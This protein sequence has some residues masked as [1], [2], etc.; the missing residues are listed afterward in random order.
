M[1]MKNHIKL[2]CLL[3]TLIGL[4]AMGV[5]L[6]YTSHV[7]ASSM[8]EDPLVQDAKVY[9]SDQGITLDEAVYRLEIQDTIGEFIAEITANEP[10]TFA[11]AWIQ[12]KPNYSIIVQFTH[13]GEKVIEPYFSNELYADLKD[14]VEV[15][16]AK[17]TLQELEAT[18]LSIVLAARDLGI[19]FEADIN[20]F[21]NQVK[22]YVT[23]PLGFQMALEAADMAIPDYVILIIVSGFSEPEVNIYAGLA[24]SE[25]TSGYSV[26]NPSGTKYISTAGHCGNTISYNGTN[27]PFVD[28]QYN[29]AGDFQYH[30]FSGF[31]IKNWA[32]DNLCCD[33]TPYYRVITATKS[34]ADQMLNE[35]VCKYG[36]TT[37]LTCGYIISKNVLPT[38]PP[39]ATATYIR[40]HRDGVNLSSGGDSGG[41]WYVGGTA[42]GVH[43]SAPGAP[44]DYDAI[45][46]AVNYFA[47]KNL[48]VM[49]AP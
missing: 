9:A 5:N 32:T 2:F 16:S 37:G 27:L 31:T 3:T 15:R 40:V 38:L 25:C 14:L 4:L 7:Q 8:D 35:F 33:S 10:D 48:S 11:G 18:Q 6:V 17:I 42:Y 30:T 19:P 24:L 13:D 43:S 39:N 44:D 46:M 45:Y 41:P 28:E 1:K 47:L 36:K 34:R 20:V 22:F 23:D 49:I 26:K 12:H 21:E 29:G